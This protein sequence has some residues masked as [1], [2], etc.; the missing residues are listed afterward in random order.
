MPSMIKKFK[1]KANPFPKGNGFAFNLFGGAEGIDFIMVMLRRAVAYDAHPRRIIIG[2]IPLNM[3]AV[4][5]KN[6]AIRRYFLLVEQLRS[7][8]STP[9]VSNYRC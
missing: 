8:V 9:L 2:S 7:A 5:I 4:P 3:N 6:T 1:E